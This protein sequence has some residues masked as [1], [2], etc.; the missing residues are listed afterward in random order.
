MKS[1]RS[2][3]LVPTVVSRPPSLFSCVPQEPL[4]RRFR[5]MGAESQFRAGAETRLEL[6][7]QSLFVSNLA[8]Q[9]LELASRSARFPVQI[10]LLDLLNFQSKS[11]CSI[12]GPN[13]FPVCSN[14][15]LDLVCCF[16]PEIAGSFMPVMREQCWIQA[17]QSISWVYRELGF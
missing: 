13:R 10:D 12:S 5:A 16:R 2:S 3:L 7:S 14:H 11:I 15:L 9:L 4:L 1:G 6:A 8:S 17:N